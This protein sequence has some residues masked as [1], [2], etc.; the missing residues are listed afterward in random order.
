MSPRSFAFGISQKEGRHRGYTDYLVYLAKCGVLARAQA[1]C[2]Q[3]IKQEPLVS[4]SRRPALRQLMERLLDKMAEAQ[5]HSFSLYK[6]GVTCKHTL[7]ETMFLTL[8]DCANVQVC[9]CV[10]CVCVCVCV[11]VRACEYI[12]YMC[13]CVYVCVCC[14]C[15][16]ACA[17]VCMRL[18]VQQT[19]N[20][21]F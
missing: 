4:E 21:V 7:G 13:A 15:I 16:C 2:S 5:H 20:H 14:M 17:C 8:C 9:A 3:V 18:H 11:C 6:V 1:L 10:C 12:L 19:C